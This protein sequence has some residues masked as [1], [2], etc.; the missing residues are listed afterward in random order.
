M[1]SVCQALK[2]A[3]DDSLE[4]NKILNQVKLYHANEST[5]YKQDVIDMCLHFSVVTSPSM[6][7]PSSG[8]TTPAAADN[9]GVIKNQN[10][11]FKPCILLV[12]VSL[13]NDEHFNEIYKSSLKRLLD[14]KTCIGVVGGRTSKS[15]VYIV[16]HDEDKLVYLNPSVSQKF[17]EIFSANEGSGLSDIELFD[18]SS[19]HCQSLG[20][21]EF[22][23]LDPSM[24][25]GFYCSSLED[26]ND[27]CESA[28]KVRYYF[29]NIFL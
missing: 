21:I 2:Q 7:D 24:L 25:L 20:R 17:V 5:V 28:K 11:I 10:S 14:M 26:L 1:E 9:L 4:S 13:G 29:D 6:S 8:T 27:L 3:L 12:P 23:E 18:N 15:P 22:A 16:S 19:F